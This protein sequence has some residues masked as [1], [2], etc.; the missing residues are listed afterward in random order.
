MQYCAKVKVNSLLI[1][2]CFARKMRNTVGANMSIN[3][4]AAYK[5]KTEFAKDWNAFTL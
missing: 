2:L 3:G 5:S 1:P 4:N